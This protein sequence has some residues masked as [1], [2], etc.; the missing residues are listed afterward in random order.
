MFN[1]IQKIEELKIQVS[2]LEF[3]KTKFQTMRKVKGNYIIF[4]SG[5]III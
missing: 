5:A 1:D 4:Y 3:Y 2:N